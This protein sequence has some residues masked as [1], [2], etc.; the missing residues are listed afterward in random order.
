M[1]EQCYYCMQYK[2]INNDNNNTIIDRH[3]ND[4]LYRLTQLFVAHALSIKIIK[5][6]GSPFHWKK[7]A[8]L[9]KNKKNKIHVCNLS[10][11]TYMYINV[12]MSCWLLLCIIIISHVMHASRY[13]SSTCA[14]A[15]LLSWYITLLLGVELQMV[16][17]KLNSF[18]VWQ[19]QL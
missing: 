14:C 8:Y 11:C 15:S 19:G 12:C 9:R 17:V 3:T 4:H 13:K 1:S 10:L 2:P 16:C 5:K 7:H 6:E 18:A